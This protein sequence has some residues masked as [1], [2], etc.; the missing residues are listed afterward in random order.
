MSHYSRGAAREREV[1][2]RYEKRGYMVVRGAG[3]KGGDLIAGKIGYP[4]LLIEVKTTAAG[5]W[6]GFG[7]AAR[8]QM[9]DA[10]ERAGW[11]PLLIWWPPHRK[12]RYIPK[13]GWPNG[14][15]ADSD[16]PGHP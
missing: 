14:A 11:T 3:S 1:Q 7:P 8:K 2:K 13:E 6:T 5:P 15:R 16:L 12:P 9:L 10:A 4:T